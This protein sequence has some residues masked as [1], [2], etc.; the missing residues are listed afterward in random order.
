VCVPDVGGLEKVI[1]DLNAVAGVAR[2]R[3]TVVLS[4]K[5]EDRVQP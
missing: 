5:F 2:T 3:T 1:R 4:T